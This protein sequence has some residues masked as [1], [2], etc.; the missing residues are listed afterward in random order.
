MALQ[1]VHS[2]KDIT[3]EVRVDAKRMLEA[4]MWIQSVLEIEIPGN[5]FEELKDGTVLCDLLNKIKPGTC[6]KYKPSQ[7]PFVAR[8]NIEIFIKGA[9]QLGVPETDIFETSDL[10]DKQRYERNIRY[11][12]N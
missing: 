12:T 6:S 11:S 5:L 9:R 7:I 4:Q 10:Y 1:K 2:T 3:K 8:N